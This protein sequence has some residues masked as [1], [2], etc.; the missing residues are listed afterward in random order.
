MNEQPDAGGGHSQP[1]TTDHQNPKG[2]LFVGDVQALRRADSVYFHAAGGVGF[3]DAILTSDDPG[4]YT[5]K[6]QL[7]FPDAVARDRR[8]RVEVDA[9]IA[10]FDTHRRWYD[11]QLPNT[12]ASATI[13]GAQ[14]HEV[15]R[16][17]AALLRVGE[18]VRP[19]WH[20]GNNTDHLNV[21]GLHRDELL[22]EVR[23]GRRLWTFLL[24]V[25]VRPQ[26]TRMVTPTTH[27]LATRP[28]LTSSRADNTAESG[29]AQ[30]QEAAE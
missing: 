11:H 27:R 13:G 30:A 22:I 15:W 6:E 12:T 2:L 9:D 16:S 25:S 21:F 23:R 7:L 17:I 20:A 19:R 29:R 26:D 14:F 8:R 5:A 4:I 28:P 18:V 1:S 3:V 10:G 24:D